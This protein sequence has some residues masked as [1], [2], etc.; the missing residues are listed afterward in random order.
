MLA[1]KL[2]ESISGAS[3]I[4]GHILFYP[5]LRGWAQTVG[6]QRGGEGIAAAG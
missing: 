5:L 1:H 4:A 6:Q 2:I 3:Q